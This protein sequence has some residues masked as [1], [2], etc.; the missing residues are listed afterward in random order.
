MST[1]RLLLATLMGHSYCLVSPC[2]PADLDRGPQER[3]KLALR[4]AMLTGGVVTVRM[5]APD[6]R[7]LLRTGLE[8]PLKFLEQIA[9][10]LV[11]LATSSGRNCRDPILAKLRQH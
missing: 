1:T 3:K 6:S 11:E 2:F 7:G 8:K 4:A 10:R 5:V 9:R